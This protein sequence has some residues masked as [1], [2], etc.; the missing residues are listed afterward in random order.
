MKKNGGE[1][2]KFKIILLLILA[3]SF[4]LVNFTVYIFFPN[5]R[6]YYKIYEEKGKY[7]YIDHHKWIY[8]WFCDWGMGNVSWNEKVWIEF[9]NG[10]ALITEYLAGWGMFTPSIHVFKYIDKKGKVVL[11]LGSDVYSADAFSEGLAAVMTSYWGYIDKSGEFAIKPQYDIAKGFSEGLAAAKP[12]WGKYYGY[13]YRS[14]EF[15]IKPQYDIAGGFSEGLAA[16][17]PAGGKYYGYIDKN[18]EFAIKPQYASASGF[19]E[20]LAAVK[21]AEGKY[22]G[23]I[24]KNGEFVIKPQYTK[25]CMSS[26]DGS[27]ATNIADVRDYGEE[28]VITKN[29]NEYDDGKWILINDKGA[30]FVVRNSEKW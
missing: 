29:K 27:I 2:M 12:A 25:T 19:S 10:L 3:L 24:N 30:P 21:P 1:F 28:C 13:I 6:M 16:V 7:Y 18:G 5:S 22:Y 23:Y 9:E 17:K 15:A 4:I 14:G 8:Y 11:R 20:G 26:T